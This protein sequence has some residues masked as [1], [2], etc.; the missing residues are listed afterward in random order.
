MNA[1]K[2]NTQ[3]LILA[4]A[5]L[6]TKLT[7]VDFKNEQRTNCRIWRQ[8]LKFIMACMQSRRSDLDLASWHRLECRNEY[9]VPDNRF[10]RGGYG[11]F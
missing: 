2:K 7:A 11:L 1:V 3:H 4:E 6:Q 8:V 10:H 5:P 9:R